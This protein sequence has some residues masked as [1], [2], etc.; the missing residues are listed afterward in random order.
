VPSRRT[1]VSLLAVV[2]MTTV[3][4]LPAQAPER[5][6]EQTNRAASDI[7]IARA[8]GRVKEDPNLNTSRKLTYPRWRASRTASWGW[9]RWLASLML[10]LAQSTRSLIW[11]AVFALALALLAYFIRILAARSAASDIDRLVTPTHVRDLD[12]RP[13]SL[14]ADIGS[15][16]RQLWDA[17]QRRA[18]LALLYRGLLSRLA[19]VHRLPIRDSTTE[20]DCL[21]L[22]RGHLDR[23][24]YDYSARLVR[25]WQRAVYGGAEADSPTVYELCDGFAASLD[26]DVPPARVTA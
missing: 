15:A 1:F 5:E 14:P 9:L 6:R 10:F 25:V 20:G 18:A 13:E 8:V 11:V 16:A 22:T 2:L 7:D 12:I 19:H 3:I 26:P 4:T 21:D 17:G 23:V 24:R